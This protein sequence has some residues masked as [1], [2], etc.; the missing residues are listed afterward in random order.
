M[1][2]TEKRLSPQLRRMLGTRSG[3]LA[4][5]SGVA[6]IAAIV[7]V[8]FLS[9]YRDS[10]KGGAAPASALVAGSLIP[11]GTAGDVV[12]GEGLSKPTTVPGDELEDGA[13]A[14]TAPIAGMVAVRDIYPGEQITAAHFAAEG[15]AVRGKL[16][17]DQRAVSV[18]VDTAHG[19]IGQL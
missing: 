9:E 3:T 13:L 6:V 18:P 17:G 5:A 16:T 11:K 10:V 12:I 7:L 1:E 19:L 2:A 8:A 14:D 4:L 15:D